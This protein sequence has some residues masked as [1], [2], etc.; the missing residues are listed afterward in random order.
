MVR[1]STIRNGLPQGKTI[2]EKYLNNI[3]HTDA[4][5]KLGIRKSKD[6]DR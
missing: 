6:R 2:H 5:R 1:L 4:Y 3:Q